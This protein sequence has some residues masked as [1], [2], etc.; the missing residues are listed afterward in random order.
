[1]I[2][3]HPVAAARN[4]IVAGTLR[5][6]PILSLIFISRIIAHFEGI[7][8]L[9]LRPGGE[10]GSKSVWKEEERG[11]REENGEIKR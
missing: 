11:S 9:L 6:I 5:A 2:Y 3:L 7:L 1:M 8:D 4:A 10:S